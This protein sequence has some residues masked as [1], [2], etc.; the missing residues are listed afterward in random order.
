MEQGGILPPAMVNPP[1][2]EASTMTMPIMANMPWRLSG[3]AGPGV[4]PAWLVP[5]IGSV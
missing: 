1:R 3:R 5:S 2:I 4:A